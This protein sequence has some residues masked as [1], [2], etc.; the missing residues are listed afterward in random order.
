MATRRPMQKSQAEKVVE[1][2]RR[3]MGAEL[4]ESLGRD[5]SQRRHLNRESRVA[6][7]PHQ[8]LAIVS[9]H[10]KATQADP[11]QRGKTDL[12]ASVAKPKEDKQQKANAPVRTA[13][14]AST[15]SPTSPYA[16]GKAMQPQ[17]AP[18]MNRQDQ[19]QPAARR[20][21]GP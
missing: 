1:A 6:Q 5:I 2:K 11:K 3:M 18:A 8:T 10:R 20:R 12:Q 13:A 21:S 15:A 4:A 17:A 9:L 7:S 19:L 14:A 16:R